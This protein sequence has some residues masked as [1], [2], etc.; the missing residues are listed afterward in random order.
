M[1]R[2]LTLTALCLSLSTLI[3]AE[4]AVTFDSLPAAVQAAA[5][6]AGGAA[7][8]TEVEKETKNGV[9]VYDIEFAAD[10]SGKYLEVTI[11]ADGTVLKKKIEADDDKDGDGDDDKNG[12]KDDDKDDK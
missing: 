4:T 2:T 12:E 6:T 1:I 7:A 3:G 10:A 8:V 11:A 5:K 9:V